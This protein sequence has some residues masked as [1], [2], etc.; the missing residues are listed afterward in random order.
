MTLDE[1]QD[2]ASTEPNAV[3]DRFLIDEGFDLLGT[4]RA[5]RDASLR[6]SILLMLSSIVQA[7]DSA[8]ADDNS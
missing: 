3:E 7:Q 5:I 2:Q 1:W 6:K 4:F 8:L